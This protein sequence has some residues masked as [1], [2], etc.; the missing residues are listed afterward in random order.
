MKD[1]LLRS[2]DDI[3]TTKNLGWGKRPPPQTLRF[4]QG[5]NFGILLGVFRVC[6]GKGEP[7]GMS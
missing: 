2:P 3:G 1:V 6:T 5:D 4:A 7:C